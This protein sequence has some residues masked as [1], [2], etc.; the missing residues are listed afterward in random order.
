[1][2]LSFKHYFYNDASVIKEDK[3][4]IIL[5]LLCTDTEGGMKKKYI[6]TFYILQIFPFW[7]TTFSVLWNLIRY[8]QSHRK[9]AAQ[10]L[11]YIPPIHAS[12]CT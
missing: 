9:L 7:R 1:M 6:L 5:Q 12:L 3:K 4:Y 8:V 2:N 11:K 10:Q